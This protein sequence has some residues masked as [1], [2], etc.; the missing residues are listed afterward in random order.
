MKGGKE[1]IGGTEYIKN[2]IFAL[3]SLPTELQ[4]TFEITL[5]ARNSPEEL[6]LYDQVIS[7]VSNIYGQYTDLAPRS[8]LERGRWK[9]QRILSPNDDDRRIQEFCERKKFSF[10]YPIFSN[11]R[12]KFISAAWIPDFQYKYLPHLFPKEE[13]LSL[14]NTFKDSARYASTVILSSKNAELDFKKFFPDSKAQTKVLSFATYPH[15][16]WFESDPKLIQKKYDL[17]DRF[18]IVSNQFWVHK[19]H[20]LIFKALKI[21]QRQN[22]RPIVV[23]TGNLHDHRCPEFAD[24]ILQTINKLDITQQIYLLG[25]IP[26]FDQI[27]LMRQ[28]IA[29]IQPSLFEGWSTVVEDARCLG[30]PMILSDIPVHLE[31][32]PL[33]SVYFERNSAEALALELA[34]IWEHFSGTVNFD[35]ESIARKNNLKAV[36]L[37]GLR[38]L[39]IAQSTQSI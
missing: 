9:L 5:I 20:V 17:P 38:F 37:L 10:V 1:W 4:S 23:C 3:N 24:E 2:I 33:N 29:V 18:F 28:A 22:I 27:Q 32:N 8:I 30:K 25:F 12:E 13:V 31:Q 35:Q 19:N 14:H 26:R 34:N 7:K 15:K 39:E 6:S 16:E 21:L 11:R 36:Q